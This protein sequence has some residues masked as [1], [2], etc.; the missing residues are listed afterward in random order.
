MYKP[1]PIIEALRHAPFAPLRIEL[2]NGEVLPVSHPDQVWVM[3]TELV[4][5]KPS[6]DDR[7]ATIGGFSVIGLDHVVQIHRDANA[8]IAPPDEEV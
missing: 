8:A 4:V 5:A 3:P 7:S 2:S 6:R 1:Q